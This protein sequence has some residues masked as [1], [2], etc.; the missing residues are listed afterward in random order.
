MVEEL[1]EAE[2]L[3]ELVLKGLHRP[4]AAFNVLGLRET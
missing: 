1:V 3:G 4:V 2:S